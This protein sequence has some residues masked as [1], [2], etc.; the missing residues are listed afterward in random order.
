MKELFG[1]CQSYLSQYAISAK[2]I[3]F[4]SKMEMTQKTCSQAFPTRMNRMWTRWLTFV[5][6]WSLYFHTGHSMATLGY[7]KHSDTLCANVSALVWWHV[8]VMLEHIHLFKKRQNN[9]VMKWKVW[10]HHR[11]Y[12]WILLRMC[13][14]TLCPLSPVHTSRCCYIHGLDKGLL[15]RQWDMKDNIL[16]IAS[17]RRYFKALF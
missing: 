11:E 10:T 3:F 7:I 6:L 12:Q 9:W 14:C 8:W 17:E 1:A 16:L 2:P 4:Y 13:R 15:L 5:T